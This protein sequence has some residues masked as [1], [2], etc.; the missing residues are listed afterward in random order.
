[1]TEAEITTEMIEAGVRA[2][3]PVDEKYWTPR[4]EIVKEIFRVMTEVRAKALR[5]A[6][7]VNDMKEIKA[8]LAAKLE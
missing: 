4:G 1:M 6:L 2:L 7:K 3:N 8:V 5:P